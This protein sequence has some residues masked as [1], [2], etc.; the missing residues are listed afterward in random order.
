MNSLLASNAALIRALPIHAALLKMQKT[1][2]Q[3]L[4]NLVE[5]II[6][7]TKLQFS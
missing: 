4:I 1:S 5:D 2:I 7:M 3:F 6:D